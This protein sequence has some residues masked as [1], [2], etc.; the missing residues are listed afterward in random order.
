MKIT[1]TPNKKKS[2]NAKATA[3]PTTK[4]SSTPKKK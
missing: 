1:I 2:N 3:K 4:K